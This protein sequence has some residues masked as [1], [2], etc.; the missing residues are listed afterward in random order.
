MYILSATGKCQPQGLIDVT[1][2]YYGFP[3]SL[4]YPHF[5][6]GDADLLNNITGMEPDEE[7]FS[8]AFVV[9]P[10]SRMVNLEISLW[11]I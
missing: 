1:D 3:I 4:S 9:Q 11:Q 7:K 5:M 8:S 10:V 6:N 2:C